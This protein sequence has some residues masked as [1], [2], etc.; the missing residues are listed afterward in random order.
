MS[1]DP[2]IPVILSQDRSP[3][4]QQLSAL[5]IGADGFL[6]CPTLKVVFR[7]RMPLWNPIN[8]VWTFGKASK[9]N[10]SIPIPIVLN[11]ENRF[12]EV[13]VHGD[14]PVTGKNSHGGLTITFGRDFSLLIIHDQMPM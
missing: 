8:L 11:F 13:W 5:D 3:P 2:V 7:L 6:S 14:W 4:T 10:L 9:G 12:G 1:N